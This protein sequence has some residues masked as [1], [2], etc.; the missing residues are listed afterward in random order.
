MSNREKTLQILTNMIQEAEVSNPKELT[1]AE[2]DALKFSRA[3]IAERLLTN[4]NDSFIERA[5]YKS[6]GLV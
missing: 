4:E 3:R 1:K 5:L 6:L 2:I